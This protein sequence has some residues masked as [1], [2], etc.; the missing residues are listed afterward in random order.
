MVGLLGLGGCTPL[1]NA[2][3]AIPFFASMHEEPAFAPYEL[4]RLPAA[5]TVPVVS[6]RGEVL[7][8]WAQTELAEVGAA[9]TNPLTPTPEVL[10]RG[11]A[12]YVRHCYVCHGMHGEGNGP[13]VGG[14]R[15]PFAP[16]VN[17]G[18]AVG[19]S[20][21]YLYAITRT[22]RG[23]MPSY[24]D[25]IHHLDRWA[26]VLYMRELQRQ[27]GGGVLPAATPAAATPPAPGTR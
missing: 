5:N 9:L 8:A 3:A 23:L 19:F 24:G 10:A 27:A 4:P 7:P 15:F 26:V 22:G 11:E 14:G 12:M 2:L 18:P 13:V 16:A 25:R 20:D 21:G 6:P 1:D 17:S